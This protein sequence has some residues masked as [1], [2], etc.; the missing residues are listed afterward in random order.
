MAY[1]KD[2]SQV[3]NMKGIALDFPFFRV[4]YVKIQGDQQKQ[5]QPEN[6]VKTA[7]AENYNQSSS[8]T[9]SI[10]YTKPAEVTTLGLDP[11]VS[12]ASV[13]HEIFCGRIQGS[14][15]VLKDHAQYP[16]PKE[17]ISPS[18]DIIV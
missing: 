17:Y 14:A 7:T 4:R 15:G 10:S 2:F 8:K 12:N 18:L 11:L 1:G 13:I 6:R 16:E 9:L 5:V 3:P